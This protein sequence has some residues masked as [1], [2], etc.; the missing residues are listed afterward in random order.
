MAAS[1]RD[2]SERLVYF[3]EGITSRFS[4]S[5]LVKEKTCSFML[6]FTT[7]SK[8]LGSIVEINYYH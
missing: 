3:T 5:D 7:G 8:S 2:S 6:Y 4:S 1:V